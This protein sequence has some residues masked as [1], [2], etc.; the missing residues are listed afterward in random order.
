VKVLAVVLALALSFGGLAAQ[1]DGKRA[2][3]GKRAAVTFR[4][5]EHHRARERLKEVR[6]VCV[7]L[8]TCAVPVAPQPPRHSGGVLIDGPCHVTYVDPF[9][10]SV[11]V[12]C[13]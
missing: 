6:R 4:A 5:K 13:G 3:R 8:A 9:D 7:P 2:K 1:A 10:H 11:F 12:L